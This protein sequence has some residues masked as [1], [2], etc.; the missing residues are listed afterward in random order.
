M[1]SAVAGSRE[2]TGILTLHWDTD[3]GDYMGWGYQKFLPTFG[4]S[5]S[6]GTRGGDC[7]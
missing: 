3:R 5:M 4:S 1:D 6:T 7:Y 2:K